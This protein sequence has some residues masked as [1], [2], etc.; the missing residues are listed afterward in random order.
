MKLKRNHLEQTDDDTT[1]NE[2]TIKTV[3]VCLDFKSQK[4]LLL[5]SFKGKPAISVYGVE[6]L[7]REDETSQIR[8]SHYKC[9]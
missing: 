9:E 5:R 4:A 3:S 8:D 1:I 2:K 7:T 6:F